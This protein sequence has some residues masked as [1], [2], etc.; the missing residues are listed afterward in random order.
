MD[1]AATLIRWWRRRR[2][3][4]A[5][6]DVRLVMADG[7]E[8]PVDCV[9]YLGRVDGVHMWEIV[10]Q[11]AREAVTFSVGWLPPRTAILGPVPLP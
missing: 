2:G 9:F 7:R 1:R 6:E 11:S 10:H 3:L 8:V 4:E 5:P